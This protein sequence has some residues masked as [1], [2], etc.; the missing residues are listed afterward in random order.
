M[1]ITQDIGGEAINLQLGE[2]I[3]AAALRALGV[4]A[5]EIVERGNGVTRRTFT[6]KLFVKITRPCRVVLN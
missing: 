4:D 1:R 3:P 2:E 5:R 6:G